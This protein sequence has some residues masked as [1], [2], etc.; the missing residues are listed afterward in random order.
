MSWSGSRTPWKP[1][2]SCWAEEMRKGSKNCRRTLVWATTVTRLQEEFV[3][4]GRKS[5]VNPSGLEFVRRGTDQTRSHRAGFATVF[6]VLRGF[7]NI[8][9]QLDGCRV[10]RGDVLPIPDLPHRIEELR[11]SILV[12][13]V[14]SMLPG[15]DH[16]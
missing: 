13:K 12:L 15:I 11:F 10:A 4:G 8:N 2:M 14:I 5:R 7:S 6:S 9:L 3:C 1:N 16:H